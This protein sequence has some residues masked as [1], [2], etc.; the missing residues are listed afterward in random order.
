MLPV[1]V[2]I[3]LA[4]LLAVDASADSDQ[5]L[6]KKAYDEQNPNMALELLS[7]IKDKSLIKDSL[8]SMYLLA[9]GVAYGKLGMIDSSLHYLNECIDN[10]RKEDR[11]YYVMRGYNA[12]GVLLKHQG[13]SELSVASLQEALAIAEEHD[14]RRFNIAEA[15]ILGNMGG[16]FFQMQDFNSAKD[17]SAR[18]LEIAENLNDTGELAYGNLR[19]AIAYEAMDSLA[20]SIH[21]NRN[22]R[23]YL[24][25]LSDY[26]SLAFVE[27]NLGAIHKKLGQ[28]DSSLYYQKKARAYAE[29][30]NEAEYISHT[31]LGIA[32][33]YLE[34][35]ALTEAMKAANEALALAEEKHFP[36][37]AKGAHDILYQVAL[38]RNQYEL[39]LAERNKSVAINDSLTAVEAKERIAELE[40]RY[41]TAQKEK[42]LVEANAEIA[43]K[44][45]F[46]LFL[47]VIIAVILVFS[48]LAIFLLLQRFR[49]KRR[50]LSQEIDTLRIQINSAL[51]VSQDKLNLNQDKINQQL[52]TPLSE[53][54]FDILKLALSEKNNREIG[55][56]LFISINT[57]KTHLKN[58]YTK[59]GVSN[60]KEAL[61]VIFK[62]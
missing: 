54:E 43:E 14:E 11:H 38:A 10:S 55:D 41:E 58:I 39:A 17:Y 62:G 28:L 47:F 7:V 12:R 45:R 59:I 37:H 33:T 3:L 42:E 35:D 5:E 31:I 23:K 20:K 44:E 29:L 48:L 51:D 9:K 32:N 57:V 22:T 52:H 56:E 16:V 40:I 24:E 4:I 15:E 19:L 53:R 2:N 49:L 46:E 30:T 18:G 1:L 6:V 61:E 26:T 60:R 21:H 36:Y 8:E 50:L 27:N 13:Q 34:M 25:V